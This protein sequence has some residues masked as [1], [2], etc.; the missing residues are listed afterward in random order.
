[1][2]GLARLYLSYTIRGVGSNPPAWFTEVDSGWAVPAWAAVPASLAPLQAV[3][4][5]LAPLQAVPA[6]LAPLQAEQ[7]FLGLLLQQS[8]VRALVVR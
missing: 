5:S 2:F 4:A 8:H 7:P 6:S 1:M 3:P